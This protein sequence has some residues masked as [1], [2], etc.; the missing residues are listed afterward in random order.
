MQ[1]KEGAAVEMPDEAEAA[2]QEPELPLEEGPFD[3]PPITAPLA[4]MSGETLA[5]DEGPDEVPDA[6][7]EI[8]EED[9]APTDAELANAG[10]AQD[11]PPA[12]FEETD[13]MDPYAPER[14]DSSDTSP[15]DGGD[16][17]SPEERDRWLNEPLRTDP[18]SKLDPRD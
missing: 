13:E 12:E 16:A 6:D 7:F 14:S 2:A 17:L 5:T 3:A 18:E 4:L 1:N 10:V 9:D 15:L 11:D 8:L